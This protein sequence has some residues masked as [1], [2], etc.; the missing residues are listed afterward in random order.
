MSQEINITL[1]EPETEP[2]AEGVS[3]E[4][5]IEVGRTSEAVDNHDERLAKIEGDIEFLKSAIANTPPPIPVDYERIESMIAAAIEIEEDEEEAE[6]E[7]LIVEELPEVE[8]EV[9]IVEEPKRE[10]TG[11]L[12]TIW[13]FIY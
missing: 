4:V 1:P 9:D 2:I 8:T 11:I 12:R 6:E 5:A 7:G 13:R 10:D 3:T